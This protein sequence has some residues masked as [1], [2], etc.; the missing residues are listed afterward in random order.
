M[1]KLAVAVDHARGHGPFAAKRRILPELPGDL[2]GF[3][4]RGFGAVEFHPLVALF[5]MTDPPVGSPEC[6][7]TAT[8]PSDELGS[9]VRQGQVQPGASLP[10]AATMAVR[11][12]PVQEESIAWWMS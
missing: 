1:G 3:T 9:D 6:Q 8:L 12:P 5:V 11:G 4:A 10:E 2:L 7:T